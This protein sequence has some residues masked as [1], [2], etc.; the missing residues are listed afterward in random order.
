MALESIMHLEE[1][2]NQ[3]S[4]KF[5]LSYNS[6]GNSGSIKLHLVILDIMG[7]TSNTTKTQAYVPKITTNQTKSIKHK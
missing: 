1:H 4:N 2:E 5:K 6:Q 3:N 7:T